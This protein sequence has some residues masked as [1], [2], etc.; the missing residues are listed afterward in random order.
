M[1]SSSTADIKDKLFGALVYVIPLLDAYVF[2]EFIFQQF[3]IL[4]L[5]YLPILPLLKFYYQFP[6][7]S[8]LVFIILFMAVVRNSNISHFIRFNAMQSI[9]IGILLS[10]FGLILA[11]VFK[12]A[13][14]SSLITETLY[15]FAFLGAL[16]S[17]I[18]GIVQSLLGRYA[19]IPTISEAA[20]SQVR[21]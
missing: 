4:G 9:L 12:P 13:F 15:N 5:I 18:F 17:S 11:Y 14:G 2:G 1:S 19:E 20:Y 8:F 6:F 16:A 21:Y 3:P 10:L 7:G